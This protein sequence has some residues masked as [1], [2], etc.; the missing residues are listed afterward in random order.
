MIFKLFT[1]SVWLYKDR[2]DMSKENM[3]QIRETDNN[4]RIAELETQL[5][6]QEDTIQKLNDVLVDQQ[7]RM[8]ALEVA[9]RHYEKRLGEIQ[10]GIG[11]EQQTSLE[12]EVPPHY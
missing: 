11:D 7:K 1:G 9:I 12:D 3:N 5:A 8:D 10:N 2:I 4:Q 6:F